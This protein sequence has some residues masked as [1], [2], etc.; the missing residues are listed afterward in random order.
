MTLAIAL[1]GILL[2]S[3]AAD[4]AEAYASGEILSS[5][6]NAVQDVYLTANCHLIIPEHVYSWPYIM[7]VL[8]IRMA[9]SIATANVIIQAN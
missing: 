9:L 8:S 3:T 6:P 4:A 1:F 5:V 7:D 2:I